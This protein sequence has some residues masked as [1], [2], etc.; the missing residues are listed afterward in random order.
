MSTLSLRTSGLQNGEVHV[1]LG[2]ELDLS[3]ALPLE[4]RLREIEDGQPDVLVLDLSELKFL[5][6]TGLRLIVA[7]HGRAQRAGR[8]LV[9]VE[10]TD[11]V[12]RI[13]RLTGVDGWL[14]IIDASGVQ[15]GALL[16]TAP[17]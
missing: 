13:F 8:R 14:D 5:D 11:A 9:I 3:S 16:R 7:A 6:S 12:R 10:G 17:E 1:H 4:D 15:D 2:G